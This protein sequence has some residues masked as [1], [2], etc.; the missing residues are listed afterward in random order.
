MSEYWDETVDFLAVGSGA[1]GMTGAIVA[2]DRGARVLV[3]EKSELYGGNTALSGGALWVPDN[4]LMFEHGIEDS[5]EEGLSYLETVT[6]GSSSPEKL[7]RYISAAPEMV[8]Y[9]QDNSQVCFEIVPLYPD[10]Y[11]E[12]VGGKSGG[13]SIEPTEIDALRL[14]NVFEQQRTLKY[15]S[16][17][18]AFLSIKINEAPLLM[19]GGRA[20]LGLMSRLLFGYLTN[21]RARLRG[22][23]NTRLTLGK[24]LAARL[25]LSLLDRDVPLWLNAPLRELIVEDG[26]VVGA[27]VER[28]GRCLRVRAMRGVLLAAGGFEH[29]AALRRQ[30]QQL[31]IGNTWTVGSES[32]VGDTISIGE[33]VG[34]SLGL[35]DEAWWTPVF[36][37]PTFDRALPMIVE[38]GL[39]GSLMVN[40][41][42][43][44]FMNEASPYNDVVK[45]MYAAN[46]RVPSI[47]AF[48]VFDANYRRQYACGPVRPGFSQPDW[49]LS[50]LLRESFLTKASSLAGLAGKL[51][52][53]AEQLGATVTRF[54]QF[55]RKGV[56]EDFGRGESSNDRYYGDPAVSPNPCLAPLETPPFYAVEVYPGDLGTK[57]GLRTDTEGRVLTA[58]DEPIPGLY[59]AGNCSASAMGRT[60]PGAGGTIGPAMSFGYLAARHATESG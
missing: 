58:S 41:S 47:P 55:A 24:A 11:P 45:R 16:R 38:K 9:L 17:L 10:Y 33:K 26:R 32:N 7:S 49:S 51:G 2:H 28:E 12:E 48:F 31:P 39:P 20:M 22:L 5:S 15:R 4:H 56:D 23:K 27:L 13:R 36:L 53:D 8:R 40:K 3:I 50:R 54:N 57:G 44:R 42:G 29:N 6:D 1:A 18:M 59:A 52:V 14:G 46:A 30:H 34:A 21:W 19:G 25:R 35:M 37:P 43:E 60:Y